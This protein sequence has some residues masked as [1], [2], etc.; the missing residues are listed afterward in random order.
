MEKFPSQ[1][2]L[3]YLQRQKRINGYARHCHQPRLKP[4]DKILVYHPDEHRRYLRQD[5]C[6]DCKAN[7]FCDQPCEVYLQWYNARLEAARIKAAAGG[8]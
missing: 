5:P 4:V 6:E 2:E 8:T 1:W 3:D 7:A